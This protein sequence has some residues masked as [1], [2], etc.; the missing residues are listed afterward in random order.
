MSMRIDR[1]REHILPGRVDHAVC[2]DVQP[3]LI[4]VSADQRD[5][6]ALDEHV[7]DGGVGRRDDAAAL[8]QYGHC[9]SPFPVDFYSPPG[10]TSTS[11]FSQSA[12]FTSMPSSSSSATAASA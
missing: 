7:G 1:A 12:P 11:S 2:L 8:D 10:V 5:P 9:G 6:L 3:L 4:E